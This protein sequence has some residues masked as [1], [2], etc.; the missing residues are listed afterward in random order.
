MHIAGVEGWLV[1]WLL[2]HLA[3]KGTVWLLKQHLNL[4]GLDLP[5]WI[6]MVL[7]LAAIL[8]VVDWWN[9]RRPR[10]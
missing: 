4:V 1:D 7:A 6:W 8:V 9:E 3:L 2:E 10:K 5:I